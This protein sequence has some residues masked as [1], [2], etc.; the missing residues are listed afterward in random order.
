MALKEFALRLFIYLRPHLGKLIFTS[1]LMILATALE[2][3]IP[4]ITGQIVDE[5]FT[6]DRSPSKTILFASILFS[7][8]LLSSL[9]SI[10]STATSAW[11]SNV[12]V[13]KIRIE[14]FNKL[15]HLP[16][17]YLDKEN[18]GVILSKLTFNVEQIA[19]AA[20]AIWLDFIKALITAIIL[21]FYLFY[22][23]WQLSIILILILPVIF[24]AIDLSA[25]RMRKSS[26]IVQQTMGKLS[27]LMNENIFGNSIIKIYQGQNIERRKLEALAKR[28]RHQRFKVSMT[29]SLNANLVNVLLGAALSFIVYFSSINLE[30]TAGE[31]LSYFTAMAMLIKPIKSLININKPLQ[32]AIAGGSS[33]FNFLDEENEKDTVDEDLVDFKGGIKFDNVSFGY[34]KNK[35]IL[36]NLNLNIEPGKTIALVGPTGSG[37][38]TIT[39]LICK[40]YSPQAGKIFIGG[41][42]IEKIK[43]LTLRKNL[44][45]VDQD[46]IL[47]NDSIKANILMGNDNVSDAELQLAISSAEAKEFINKLPNGLDFKIGDNG[48][49]LS[50]GQRQRLSIARAILKN[51]PILILDEATSSL[52]IST[53]K[54]VQKAINKMT[55]DRTTIIIAHRL[56]TIQNADL[57]VVLSNGSIIEQGSHKSL[58]KKKGYYYQLVNDQFK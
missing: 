48:K 2:T 20:S 24:I 5:L 12:V 16:K 15:L 29:G 41:V 43:N 6:Q 4:E 13:M 31:F 33:V 46:T 57:I 27:H 51:S 32:I 19:A 49:L 14:M 40:F 45:F 17:S 23:N 52:D 1:L 50:G 36:K 11:V 42:N 9:F 37:K 34:E 30:M 56:S 21:T 55:K 28:V 7:V 47:F 58:M 18:S 10:A 38:T 44:S 22:K 39:E 25:K 35:R 8:F 3:T 53:E 26:Q 54:L